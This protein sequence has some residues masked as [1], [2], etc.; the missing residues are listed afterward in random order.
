[1][2]NQRLQPNKWSSYHLITRNTVVKRAPTNSYWNYKWFARL[3][4]FCQ[5]L[6]HV[7]IFQSLSLA[8]KA[9]KDTLKRHH[10]KVEN[11][12]MLHFLPKPHVCVCV[13]SIFTGPSIVERSHQLVHHCH[14]Y[15]LLKWRHHHRFVLFHECLQ[16]FS[17]WDVNTNAYCFAEMTANMLCIILSE[18]KFFKKWKFSPPLERAPNC[19]NPVCR[20]LSICARIGS[21]AETLQW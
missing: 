21:L 19:A 13:H 15:L 16:T 12:Q 4:Y 2:N 18:I 6:I 9:P 8:A 3:A 7:Q 14:V 10:T 11:V 17:S 5:K 1:M 20:N